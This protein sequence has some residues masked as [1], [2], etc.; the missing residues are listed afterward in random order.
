MVPVEVSPRQEVATV[1][2]VSSRPRRHVG[3]MC[4]NCGEFGQISRDC[5]QERADAR[6]GPPSP[7][8]SGGI[9]CHNCSGWGHMARDCASEPSGRRGGP[10]GSWRGR[11]RGGPRGDGQNGG[12]RVNLV[13]TGGTTQVK[14]R[15]MGVQYGDGGEQANPNNPHSWEFG[16][17][18]IVGTVCTYD[19][20]AELHAYFLKYVNV[21]VSGCVLH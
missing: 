14:T 5:P 9:K 15:E 19:A 18:P 17:H 11:Y 21:T 12:V 20:N 6:N 4:Y 7:T 3:G 13:S 16:A 10:R 2:V 8:R 1:K